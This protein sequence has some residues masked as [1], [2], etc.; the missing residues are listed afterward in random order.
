MAWRSSSRTSQLKQVMGDIA[1]TRTLGPTGLNWTEN[2]D[3]ADDAEIT[4]ATYFL[5]GVGFISHN[6]PI[7]INRLKMEELIIPPK[8]PPE[9]WNRCCSLA[10]RHS[11]ASIK[12]SDC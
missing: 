3:N 7:F 10:G 5:E 4:Q 12:I 6:K 8:V 9:G 2:A 11:L 1:H